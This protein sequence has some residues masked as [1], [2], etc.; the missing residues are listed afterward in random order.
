MTFIKKKLYLFMRVH[1][2]WPDEYQLKKRDI[3]ETVAVNSHVK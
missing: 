1:M 2:I 3:S